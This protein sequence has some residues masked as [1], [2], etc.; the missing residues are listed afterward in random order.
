MPINFGLQSNSRIL[1][2]F[3][4]KSLALDVLSL[5]INYYLSCVNENELFNYILGVYLCT[6]SKIRKIKDP[7]AFK[8]KKSYKWSILAVISNAMAM[9]ISAIYEIRSAIIGCHNS[10]HSRRSLEPRAKAFIRLQ[11]SARFRFGYKVCHLQ[12][13]CSSYFALFSQ[14]SER[15]ECH[16]RRRLNNGAVKMR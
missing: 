1:I 7:A 14:K 15:Y 12:C 9:A 11:K 3:Y 5:Q 13:H 6:M 16:K 4:V 2:L 10:E 8:I